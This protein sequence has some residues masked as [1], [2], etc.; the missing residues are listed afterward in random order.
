[1]GGRMLPVS[2]RGNEGRRERWRDE[3]APLQ[4]RGPSL[5]SVLL[6]NSEVYWRRQLRDPKLFAGHVA[7]WH[8]FSHDLFPKEKKN[9]MGRKPSRHVALLHL[10]LPARYPPS[11]VQQYASCLRCCDKTGCLYVGDSHIRAYVSQTGVAQPWL[12]Q[13][14]FICGGICH[15]DCGAFLPNLTKTSLT[16]TSHYE[17]TYASR[18]SVCK[19]IYFS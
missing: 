4:Q 13:K 6:S 14:T 5:L 9:Q 16:W 1:M 7:K 15:E 11:A 12:R 17:L 2:A 3:A 8:F 10:P 19:A 18:C